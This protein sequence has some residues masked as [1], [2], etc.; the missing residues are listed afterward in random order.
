MNETARQVLEA[1]R[2]EYQR[3][4]DEWHQH[5]EI[6]AQ[7]LDRVFKELKRLEAIVEG[8]DAALAA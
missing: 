8:L 6:Q 2:A 5:Y 1:E 4:Y 3:R 7:D